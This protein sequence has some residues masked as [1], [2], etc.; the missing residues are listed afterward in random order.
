MSVNLPSILVL[1]S[2]ARR[3]CPGL[4]HLLNLRWAQSDFVISMLTAADADFGGVEAVGGPR[5]AG[6]GGGGGGCPPPS[7]LPMA[8]VALAIDGGEACLNR[9]V[10]RRFLR[11]QNAYQSASSL[12]F[13]T[14][15]V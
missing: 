6:G 11:L 8:L 5:A 12:E 13:R 9:G 7:A 14:S 2:S 4:N 15:Y 10:L 1:Q 3:R